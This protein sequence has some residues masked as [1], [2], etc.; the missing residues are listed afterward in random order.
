[1]FAMTQEEGRLA[2]GR[3]LV[4]L[5]RNP[6]PQRPSKLGWH[7]GKLERVGVEQWEGGMRWGEAGGGQTCGQTSPGRG[8][9]DQPPVSRL[10]PKPRPRPGSLYAARSDLC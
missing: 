1:M 3:V 10:N 7:R 9:W 8:G 5:C 2:H 6:V 4:S